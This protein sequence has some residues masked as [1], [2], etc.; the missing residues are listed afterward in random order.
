MKESAGEMWERDT[1]SPKHPPSIMGYQQL[2]FDF[3][4]K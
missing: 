1:G 4:T 3:R 2:P